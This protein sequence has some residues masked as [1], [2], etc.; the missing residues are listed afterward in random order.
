M[1]AYCAARVGWPGLWYR[2]DNHRNREP[3]VFD[4]VMAIATVALLA[5]YLGIIVRNIPDIDLI[6]VCLIAVGACA[7]DF[8]R[9]SFRGKRR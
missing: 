9:S 2:T 7:F 1:P 4:K 5:G 6:I 3:Q 8:Y